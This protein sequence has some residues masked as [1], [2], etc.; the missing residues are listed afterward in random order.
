MKKIPCRKCG[1]QTTNM[2]TK[3]CDSCKTWDL[4]KKQEKR[5]KVKNNGNQS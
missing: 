2:R 3:I 4:I 5:D 1:D